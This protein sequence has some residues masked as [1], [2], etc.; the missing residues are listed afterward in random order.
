MANCG[1]D[2]LTYIHNAKDNELKKLKEILTEIYDIDGVTQSIMYEYLIDLELELSR[3]VTER[4]FK[5]TRHNN[6]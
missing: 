1:L 6:T 2:E 3:E 5:R 4:Y